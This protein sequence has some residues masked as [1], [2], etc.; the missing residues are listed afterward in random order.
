[1]GRL[2]VRG[3][4]IFDGEDKFYARGV[5]YG[6]FRPNSRGERYPEPERA[7]EDF[8]LMREMGVNV[9]RTYV[10]P[11]DW[12]FELAAK[13]GLKLMVGIPW[14]FH[15]AFLDSRE[16]SRDI[17][18]TIRSAVASTRTHREVIFAYILGNEI[19]SDIVRWHGARRVSRFLAELCDIGKHLDPEGLFTYANYPSTEY[20]ELNFLDLICFNVYLHNEPD[21]RRYLTHLMAL[22]G[23]RPLILSESGMD[24]IREGEA[25]QA[26]LLE[27]QSRAAFELGL[28]GYIVFAFTDEWHTGGSEITDW[29]FGLVTRER[30]RKQAF[31]A[32]GR[33]FGA[34][35]PPPLAAPPKA[36]VVVAAYNAAAS[37]ARCL[38]SLKRLNYPDYEIIVVDD[39][40]T[41]A[42]G[43]IAERAGVRT[44]R[45]AHRGLSDA[46]NAGAEAAAGELIAFI[47]ADAAA[48]RD[49]L[50]HLVETAKRRAAAAAG[51]PNFPPPAA[52][53]TAA[54]SAAAPGAPREVASSEDRLAQLCGC[55]MVIEKSALD[56]IGG[57]D[58]M[59]TAA[60]DDVD[61]SWRLLER[62]ATLAYAPGAVVI[63]E[64]R[65]TLGTYL[66]QQK[67]YGRGEAILFRK[68]PGRRRDSIYG[69]GWRWPWSAG[70]RI[71]YGAF[72]RG[73]F[74]TIYSAGGDSWIAQAPLTFPWIALSII[75][76]VA[77]VIDRVFA[78]LGI[79]GL[80]SS[81]AS[82]G[83]SA[84]TAP[85]EPRYS[86]I[87]T[88][89]I[90]AA[91]WMLGPLARSYEYFR[92]RWRFAA[93]AASRGKFQ[94][95]GWV[96]IAADRSNSPG[97]VPRD[98]LMQAIR[99]ALIRR[100]AAVAV[101]DG[102]EPFDLEIL[103]TPALRIPINAIAAEQGGL[104]L[105]WR[106]GVDLKPI[107]VSLAALILLP[108]IAAQP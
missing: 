79:V 8:A 34:A 27:W 26:E 80:M 67:S 85:L 103:M 99:G 45:R 93:A 57:F 65:R 59:F 43:D 24:T 5:S 55:N 86:G 50:Y 22:S 39:G 61:L 63:H 14:P 44:I 3:K 47:D 2:V 11:P 25:H 95:R 30:V 75:L 6:P 29:A 52:S 18:R 78:A 106:L 69:T 102:F 62:D 70:N 105:R 1:M 74:Q 66:A 54:A 108:L 60:G 36:S 94:T 51:G 48:D 84:A 23:E 68:Y 40:S 83:A 73:L 7:A 42:T 20:L 12:M 82:A 88:R 46:R 17:R 72:G 71:Y 32:V 35:I 100:G 28:S 10:P 81:I 33:V 21:Y 13:S 41:D 31:A 97:P 77:G 64:R 4:Y 19:R 107:L 53:A 90:L 101:S 16:M 104:T 56:S 98:I 92:G 37:L 89:A 91:F 38:D 76:I 9:I 15:M 49:W 87:K 58:P 96:T